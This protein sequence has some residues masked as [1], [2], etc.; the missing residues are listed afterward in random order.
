MMLELAKIL[1]RD[2]ETGIKRGLTL[3]EPLL[4]I[5]L[6]L[7][8]ASIIVSIL[9]GILSINDLAVG[10]L[11]SRFF[12][13]VSTVNSPTRRKTRAAGFTLIELLVVLAILTLLAGLVGPRVLGQLGAKTKTAGCR[14]PTWQVART[15]QAGRAASQ[16]RGRPQA[17]VTKPG[18]RRLERPLPEGRRAHRPLGQ[19]LPIRAQRRCGRDRLLGA[20]AAGGEARTPTSATPSKPFS[21]V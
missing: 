11:K 1:N 4:I 13:D 6:G 20:D 16:H 5:V 7:M 2:V 21:V 8:I 12:K 9:L 10:P 19:A 15:L 17:L 3:V 18:L 14:S